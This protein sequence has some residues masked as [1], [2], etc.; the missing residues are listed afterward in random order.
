MKRILW[1]IA[2]ILIGLG[3][4]YLIIGVCQ[5]A[6]PTELA[7]DKYADQYNIDPDL[8]WAIRHAESCD[9]KWLW[10]DSYAVLVKQK[11][12]RSKV[13]A[14]YIKRY[15]RQ[16][17]WCT[18]DFQVSPL[19]AATYGFTNSPILLGENV[20]TN[21]RYAC[22]LLYDFMHMRGGRYVRNVIASYNLGWAHTHNGVYVNHAYVDHVWAEY[23]NRRNHGGQ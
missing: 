13:C 7:I 19:V 21:C 15:G 3:A 17:Y 23:S 5:S 8:L 18:G 22:K 14:R 16:A 11:W 10:S 2:S 1:L 4:A 6:S 9:G 12:T 20:Y